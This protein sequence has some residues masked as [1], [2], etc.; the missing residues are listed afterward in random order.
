MCKQHLLQ[1]DIK[2]N[3]FHEYLVYVCLQ[4]GRGQEEELAASI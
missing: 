2:F 1:L 4:L 3:I